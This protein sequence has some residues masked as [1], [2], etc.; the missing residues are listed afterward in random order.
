MLTGSAVIPSTLLP[1]KRKRTRAAANHRPAL[2]ALGL[3]ERPVLAVAPDRRELRGLEGMIR[4]DV[5]CVVAREVRMLVAAVVV[6]VVAV[7]A[8][9]AWISYR[10]W[11]QR[12]LS[13][14][15]AQLVSRQGWERTDTP[16]GLSP[17]EL[18]LT[19]ACAR[20]VGRFGIEYGLRAPVSDADDSS[21]GRIV[22]R[23][24]FLWWSQQ[25]TGGR[26][27][28]SGWSVPSGVLH[29]RRQVVGVIRTTLHLPRLLLVPT[30]AGGD[31]IADGVDLDF[32]TGSDVAGLRRHRLY[33]EPG[34]SPL[35]RD[36]LGERFLGLA[37][38]LFQGRRIAMYED[39]L[40]VVGDPGGQDS[41]LHR[42]VA[43]LSAAM[44]DVQTLA[45]AIPQNFWRA[46][47]TG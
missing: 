2:A 31:K 13:V 5:E 4:A 47:V 22:E 21:D 28:N 18:T 36:L 1:R 26:L 40:L 38:E 46:V 14:S 19:G 9:A 41:E 30:G 8:A 45:N 29:R 37:N 24:A 17:A 15:L 16:G 35:A 39:V 7:A 20:G 42:D 27:A 32:A 33:V 3:L 6:V 23:A 12:R 43:K 34:A 44:R 25:S 10:R 11:D